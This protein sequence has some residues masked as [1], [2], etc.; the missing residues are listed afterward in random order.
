LPTVN[1]KPSRRINSTNGQSQL[2]PALHLPRVRPFGRKDSDAHVADQFG[3]E[4]ALDEPGRELG[5][6]DRLGDPLSG[7]RGGVDAQGHA[8]ARVVDG[9][10]R[11]RPRIIGVRQ[12]VADHDLG[13]ARHGDDVARPGPIGRGIDTVEG[14]GDV[15]LGQAHPLDAPVVPAPRHEVAL[16][17]PAVEDPA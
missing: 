17:H 4:T 11:Q 16:L 1:S 8:D 7:E 12:R 3:I 10:Y 13:N 5:A 15:H 14:L 6:R 2:A 9:D